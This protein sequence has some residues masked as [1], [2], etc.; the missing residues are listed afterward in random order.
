MRLLLILIILSHT[1]LFAKPQSLLE[2]LGKEEQDIHKSKLS[3]QALD[4]NKN[5]I[6]DILD[7]ANVKLKKKYLSQICGSN[8][9]LDS[10]RFL[11]VFL[12]NK[13]NIFNYYGADVIESLS[14]KAT[15]E[16]FYNKVLDRLYQY[17]NI[18]QV[19]S[20][21]PYC[22]ID[23]NPSVSKFLFRVMYLRTELTA[24]KLLHQNNLGL[25]VIKELRRFPEQIK[26]CPLPE[27][28]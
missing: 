26:S 27:K 25:N 1:C 11:E 24:Q 14:K 9:K 15:I 8:R 13:G 17:I 7:L 19:T 21:T 10:F 12:Q 6:S 22:L 18:T 23:K 3:K 16:E 5:L 28:K 4:F 2:C 20:P